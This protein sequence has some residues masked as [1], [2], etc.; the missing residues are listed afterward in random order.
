MGDIFTDDIRRKGMI[1]AREHGRKIG[2]LSYVINTPSSC[3]INNIHVNPSAEG[4]GAARKM[5]GQLARS[6]SRA[7]TEPYQIYCGTYNKRMLYLWAYVFGLDKI[8]F[9]SVET[10]KWLTPIEASK[11]VAKHGVRLYVCGPYDVETA[12]QHQ[13][14]RKQKGRK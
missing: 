5:L 7:L 6:M 3:W 2:Q 1:Y 12:I 10:R 4:R 9:Q 8:R 11:Q 14:G 13:R